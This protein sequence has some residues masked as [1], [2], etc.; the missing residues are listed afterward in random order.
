MWERALTVAT[1]S[2]SI[3]IRTL[4]RCLLVGPTTAI[5]LPVKRREIVA[6]RCH[7]VSTRPPR[8]P[9]L[10]LRSHVPE[11]STLLTDS[12]ITSSSK[13][14]PQAASSSLDR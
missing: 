2:P 10:F 1:A 13:L 4:P 9:A 11:V 12:W 6:P 7:D 14:E 5:P 3:E 8:K